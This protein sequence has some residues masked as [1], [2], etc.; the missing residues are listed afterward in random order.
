[1]TVGFDPDTAAEAR[2]QCRILTVA[3]VARLRHFHA[4]TTSHD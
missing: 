3:L 1:M 4:S 2:R